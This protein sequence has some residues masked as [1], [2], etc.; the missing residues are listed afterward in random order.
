MRAITLDVTFR[1]GT[2]AVLARIPVQTYDTEFAD[3]AGK[4]PVPKW[5]AKK[6]VRSNEILPDVPKVEWAEIPERA[7][8]AEAVLTYHPLLPVYRA[9]LL[10]KQVDLSGRDPVVMTRAVVTLP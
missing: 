5:L 7:K 9:A 4:F 6:V 3:A 10:A 2:G 8:N 1:D